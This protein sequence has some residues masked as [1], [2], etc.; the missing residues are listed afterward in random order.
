VASTIYLANPRESFGARIPLLS[1]GGEDATSG[2]YREASF[3]G[4]DGVVLVKNPLTSTTPS[5]RAK[6]ASQLFLDRASTP[7]LL[8][9]GT[10]APKNGVLL[11][12]AERKL[13]EE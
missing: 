9:R 4:A 6:V 7:P 10:R 8:R 3:Q 11:L 12:Q 2:K 13:K 5:A 1:R